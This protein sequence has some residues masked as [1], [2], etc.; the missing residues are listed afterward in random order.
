[1]ISAS[2]DSNF[3][4]AIVSES[5]SF[6]TFT[7]WQKRIGDFWAGRR[8]KPNQGIL[9]RALIRAVENGILPQNTLTDLRIEA[10]PP[11]LATRNAVE[12]AT[13]QKLLI[14]A[15]IKSREDVCGEMGMDY[16]V[17][18][19]KMTRDT[20]LTEILEKIQMI[21]AAGIPKEG[22]VELFKKY[23]TDFDDSMLNNIFD[24]SVMMETQSPEK[25]E[26]KVYNGGIPKSPKPPKPNKKTL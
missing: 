4:S 12:E 17:Q 24:D 19:Q 5:P 2:A 25:E 6:K 21:K 15:G 18:K 1:M 22:A 10:I 11:S 8:T 7:S 13:A 14:E 16:E 23:Y 20:S 26:T 9:W 3:A